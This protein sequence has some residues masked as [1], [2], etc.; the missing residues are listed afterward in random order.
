MIVIIVLVVG[1][2]LARVIGLLGVRQLNSWVAS[3]R[4]GLAL[5]LLFTAASHF[6]SMRHD[7]A[8]MV[9]DFIPYPMAF[10]YFTGVCEILGAIGLLVSRVRSIAGLTLIVFFIL[11]LPANIHAATSGVTLR[12]EAATPL[13]LRVPMQLL[14]IAL[15]WW[16][17][18][19]SRA[20]SE[21]K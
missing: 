2:L 9:P 3:V 17:T 15:T 18:L 6:T 19:S 1:V 8:R 13:L 11:V 20:R 16:S 10:V 4:V 5:M 14:F 12:G 21:G 7:L